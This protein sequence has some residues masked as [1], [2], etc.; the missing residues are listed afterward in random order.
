MT[1]TIDTDS[2]LDLPLR[3]A[4]GDATTLRGQL[5]ARATVVVFLRHFG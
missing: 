3:T 4:G 1:T 5:G 2:L